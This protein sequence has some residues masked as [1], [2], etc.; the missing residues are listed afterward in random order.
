MYSLTIWHLFSIIATLTMVSLA[1]VYAGRKVKNASDFSVGGRK[2]GPILIAGTVTGTL[3]G[4]A[5]TIGTAELAFKF[6]LSAWWFTLGAG[7]ACLLLSVLIAGPLQ[8]SELETVPQFLVKTYGPVAGPLASIFSST[9]IFINIMAQI[10]S[11]IALLGSMFALNP[12]YAAFITVFLV[13]CYVFFGGFMGTGIVGFVKLILIYGSLLITGVLA[14]TKAGGLAGLT[15]SFPPFPWFS[16]FGRGLSAD[17]AAGFSV[18]VGVLSTQTYWQA[19]FSGKNVQA[20]RRGAW[21]SALL[22]LPCGLAGIAV[23]MYMKLSF[24]DMPA[25]E[26]LPAFVLKFLPPWLGG[27]VLAVLLV[28]VIGTA[29]GLALGVSTML[30][31]DF[32]KKFI[33]TKA[34]GRHLLTVSRVVLVAVTGSTILLVIGNLKTMILEWSF[35]SMGLRGATI[36]LPLMG[37]IFFRKYVSPTAGVLAL[38]VGPMTDLI[39]KIAFPNIMDPLYAG[40]LASFLV[41]ALGS[42]VFPGSKSRQPKSGTNP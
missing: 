23:G 30:T 19:M 10:L 2:A 14:Y 37:A 18:M 27:V 8:D 26:A 11:A 33:N 3:I 34:S 36:F 1:G 15:Q 22:M 29:A 6:G 21:L 40:L 20:A 16:L 12:V 5:S 17:A 35:L 32:Y 13:V 4:G 31:N 28:A 24:P 38:V 42:L 7:L 39:W 9:G 41:L 25:A